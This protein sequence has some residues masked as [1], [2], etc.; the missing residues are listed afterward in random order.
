LSVLKY[1]E[2]PPNARFLFCRESGFF[3][4]FDEFVN[5]HTN[6]TN[7]GLEMAKPS[8]W[9]TLSNSKKE[10]TVRKMGNQRIQFLINQARE[11]TGIDV[12]VMDKP[13]LIDTFRAAIGTLQMKDR[14][15]ISNIEDMEM[16]L[17]YLELG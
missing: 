4:I 2:C 14:P 12:S 15:D 16:M 11:I 7:G 10:D 8:D 5:I 17:E 3:Q 9:D 6:V 1:T 13:G